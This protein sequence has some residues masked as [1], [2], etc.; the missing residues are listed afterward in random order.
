M[1]FGMMI[2]LLSKTP[3]KDKIC[4]AQHILM[5]FSLFAYNLC[6]LILA[7]AQN[8][9]TR[10]FF[11]GVR[12]FIMVLAS[13]GTATL[14]M[15]KLTLRIKELYQQYNKAQKDSVNLIKSGENF[16][17]EGNQNEI[18]SETL[19]ITESYQNKGIELPGNFQMLLES[20]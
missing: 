2:Y 19:S 15:L 1:S 5:E 6:L 18:N 16:V 20:F 17:I 7:I 11:G 10:A 3:L 13:F 8:E 12:I 4:F 14:I 9:N